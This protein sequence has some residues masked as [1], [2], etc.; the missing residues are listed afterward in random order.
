MKKFNNLVLAITYLYNSG[1][2]EDFTKNGLPKIS[3]VK[4]VYDGIVDRELIDECWRRLYG[5][6]T[7]RKGQD[8]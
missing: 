1:V 7:F 8:V 5:Y 2:Y 6:S 4:K 3:A